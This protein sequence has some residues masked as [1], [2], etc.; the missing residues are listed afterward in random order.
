[1]SSWIDWASVR[2]LYPWFNGSKDKTFE[3]YTP[4]LVEKSDVV[5]LALPS[6][7]AMKLAPQM[8]AKGKKVIDLG[9]DFRMQDT[10]LYSTYY[11]AEHTAKGL[12]PEAVYGLP[13]WNCESIR[14]AKL[15]ANPGCYPTAAILPLAPL[16]KE[17]LIEQQ[18]ITINSLSGIS[19]AGRAGSVEL[20][21]CEVNESA[22][23]YKV[24]THQHIPEIA[25]ALESITGLA[26]EF[27]FIPHIIP[28]IRGIFTTITCDLTRSAS[29]DDVTLAFEKY[30]ADAPFVDF[31][32]NQ[33]PAI[34]DVV[35]TNMISFSFSEYQ[36]SGKLVLHSVIDNLIK[37][38]AGQAVQNMNLMCGFSECEG[39]R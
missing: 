5:F 31:T 4:D 37:G 35:N 12:L 18:N 2:S 22:S 26:P 33:I 3:L 32:S 27:T 24:G 23:A 38:A 30:Y 6:G 14:T 28:I 8:L 16:L 1:M 20:S 17:G 10:N 7:E 34:K 39:L 11:Q 15:I 9:G 25:T 36:K 13:E 29:L 21:F 19:G